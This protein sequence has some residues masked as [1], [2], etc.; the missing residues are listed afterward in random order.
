VCSILTND[1]VNCQISFKVE[2]IENDTLA[3]AII[4]W[5]MDNFLTS[6]QTKSNILFETFET[7]EKYLLDECKKRWPNRQAFVKIYSMSN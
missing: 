1:R 2:K 3:P 4:K 5:E 6:D 7:A